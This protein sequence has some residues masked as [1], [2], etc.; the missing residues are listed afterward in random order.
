[1]PAAARKTGQE[2]AWEALRGLWAHDLCGPFAGRRTD[3]R[4]RRRAGAGAGRSW[5]ADD[6]SFDAATG[7]HAANLLGGAG[8]NAADFAMRRRWASARG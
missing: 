8:A 7:G 5:R 4:G 2:L 3:R 1:M 6:A